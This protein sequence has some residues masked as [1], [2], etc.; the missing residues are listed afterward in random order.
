MASMQI[1]CAASRLGQAVGW[2]CAVG[3]QRQWGF[4]QKG[5]S[6]GHR[7]HDIPHQHSLDRA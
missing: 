4:C 5:H 6:E 2:S 3:Y 7:G 1:L